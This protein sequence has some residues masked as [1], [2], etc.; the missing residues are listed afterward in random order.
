M[1]SQED[2]LNVIINI[3]CAVTLNF[4]IYCHVMCTVFAVPPR[5]ELRPGRE[6]TAK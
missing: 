5:N 3:M 2:T 6:A 4:Y 1:H